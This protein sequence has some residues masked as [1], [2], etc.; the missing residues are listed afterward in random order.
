MIFFLNMF[1]EKKSYFMVHISRT[2][3]IS[4]D[5]IYIKQGFSSWQI[6]SSAW[7]K[8]WEHHCALITHNIIS[9]INTFNLYMKNYST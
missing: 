7:K 1:I 2:N 6:A 4:Y 3:G 9:K 8:Y 5:I